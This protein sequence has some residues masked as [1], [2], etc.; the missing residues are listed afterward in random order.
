MPKD[1]F[2]SSSYRS[3][4][5]PS[6]KTNQ[7]ISHHRTSLT[8][9]NNIKSILD[10]ISI[11]NYIACKDH[12]LASLPQLDAKTIE[13]HLRLLLD[14][15]E[16]LN[17]NHQ[18]EQ[19]L[20]VEHEALEHNK[21]IRKIQAQINKDKPKFFESLYVSTPDVFIPPKLWPAYTKDGMLLPKYLPYYTNHKKMTRKR[22]VKN[23]PGEFP[24]KI[25]YNMISK[26]TRS[27]ISI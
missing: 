11:K 24:L 10:T 21:S 12:P 17:L 3:R 16:R 9:P 7:Q 23:I 26:K 4:Q 27:L 2:Y 14:E 18:L 6:L 8:Y 25:I 1:Q 22:N 20:F 13:K 19:P 15:I 5:Q